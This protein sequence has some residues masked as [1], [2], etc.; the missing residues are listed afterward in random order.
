MS[1]HPHPEDLSLFILGRRADEA[2]GAIRDHIEECSDCR[3]EVEECRSLDALFRLPELEIEVPPTQWRRISERLEAAV[4]A[5]RW[6]AALWPTHR[7]GTPSWR[8]AYSLGLVVALGIVLSGTGMYYWKN[9]EEQRILATLVSSGT[10][11]RAENPF[12]AYLN[13]QL[14]GN[15]F[16]GATHSSGTNPFAVAT[17]KR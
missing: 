2:Y 6:G 17:E 13:L 8:L 1:E 3:R 14:S 9:S 16:E 7:V 10:E 15:P 5:R 12:E 4:P 11:W